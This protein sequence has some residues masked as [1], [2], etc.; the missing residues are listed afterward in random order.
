MSVEL[1]KSIRHDVLAVSATA[2][3]ATAGGG[4]AI[5]T[6]KAGRRVALTVTPGMFANG[7][8]QV[9]GPASAKG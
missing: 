4:Y 9:E 1:L 6:L 7:Y 2:S 5:E 3:T 8:V